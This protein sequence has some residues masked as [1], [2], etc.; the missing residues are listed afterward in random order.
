MLQFGMTFA[1]PPQVPQE[2]AALPAILSKSESIV[3]TKIQCERLL[4]EAE[5]YNVPENAALESVLSLETQFCDFSTTEESS[6]IFRGKTLS[7]FS[8]LALKKS[9]N[10]TGELLPVRS[11]QKLSGCK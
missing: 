10:S 3:M 1:P 4:R 6:R 8:V 11:P 5:E 9:L 2:Q 7:N